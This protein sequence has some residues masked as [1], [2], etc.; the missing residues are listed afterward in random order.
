MG[1]VGRIGQLRGGWDRVGPVA[2]GSDGGGG[3]LHEA[4]RREQLGARLP[5]VRLE[6]G[7]DGK[8][9]AEPVV[10][11]GGERTGGGT[12]AHLG[13]IHPGVATYGA[14]QTL[15]GRPGLEGAVSGAVRFAARIAATGC[16]FSRLVLVIGVFLHVKE[17]QPFCFLNVRLLALLAQLLP[18]LAQVL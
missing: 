2:G 6:L 16:L 14:V 1:S 12:E 9:E 3:H 18:L 8:L 7:I 11:D 17:T 5:Q 15:I 10:I 4:G 13:R